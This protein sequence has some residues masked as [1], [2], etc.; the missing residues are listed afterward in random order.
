MASDAPENTEQPPA[1]QSGP[2]EAP[3][4]SVAPAPPIPE[5]RLPSRKDTSLREFLNKIDDYAPIVC[6]LRQ[7]SLGRFY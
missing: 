7:N 6:F 2:V 5:S 3:A 4:D 1:S